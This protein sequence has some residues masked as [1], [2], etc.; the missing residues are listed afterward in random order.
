MSTTTTTTAT[1]LDSSGGRREMFA[2]LFDSEVEYCDLLATFKEQYCKPIKD[3][4]KLTKPQYFSRI[5]FQRLVVFLSNVDTICRLNF[6]FR[7]ELKARGVDGVGGVLEQ[8]APLFKMYGNYAADLHSAMECVQIQSEQ[9]DRFSKFLLQ[10]EESTQLSLSQLMRRPLERIILYPVFSSMLVRV[11]AELADLD[12][13]ESAA[14][15]FSQTSKF[16]LVQQE[17]TVKLERFKQLLNKEWIGLQ[18]LMSGN[19]QFLLEGDLTK[20]SRKVTVRYR[21]LLFNDCLVYGQSTTTSTAG[22][23]IKFK[24]SFP[25][26]GLV[27]QPDSDDDLSFLI[28][29]S[30]KSFKVSAE[31]AQVQAKWLQ[32]INLAI[33]DVKLNGKYVVKTLKPVM[34]ADTE[35]KQCMKCPKK[36]TLFYRRHHCRACGALVCEKCSLGRVRISNDLTKPKVRVCDECACKPVEELM[37]TTQQHKGGEGEGG[38]EDEEEDDYS[39]DDEV[40]VKKRESTESNEVDSTTMQCV[41]VAAHTPANA[42]LGE[43][44]VLLEGD[45]LHVEHVVNGWATGTNMRTMQSGVFPASCAQRDGELLSRTHEGRDRSSSGK[46][47][48]RRVRSGSSSGGGSGLLLQHLRIPD[49]RRSSSHL[50]SSP[51]GYP[52]PNGGGG[53]NSPQLSAGQQLRKSLGE[54]SPTAPSGTGTAAA[55]ASAERKSLA[56]PLLTFTDKRSLIMN[57]I[58]VTERTYIG[59]LRALLQVFVRPLIADFK[60]GKPQLGGTVLTQINNEDGTSMSVF[61]A[62]LEHIELLNASFLNELETR[63]QFW[64]T[65][66]EDGGGNSTACTVGDVFLRFANLFSMYDEFSSSYEFASKTL[67]DREKTDA[68]LSK[69]FEDQ[70]EEHAAVLKQTTLLSLLITP[71][72]RVPRYLLLLK[73]MQKNTPEDHPDFAL[74]GKAIDTVSKAAN[75]INEHIRERENLVH[76]REVDREFPS[77]KIASEN[78]LRM[79]IYRGTVTKQ[80]RK[81]NERYHLVLFSDMLLYQNLARKHSTVV[82][83][84]PPKRIMLDTMMVQDVSDVPEAFD[85]VSN[86]KSFRV[87]AEDVGEKTRWTKHFAEALDQLGVKA[88]KQAAPVWKQDTLNCEICAGKFT[89]TF[90]RHH[91]RACGKCICGD[92]SKNRMSVPYLEDGKPVRVCD[93]C[94]SI[95][96]DSRQLEEIVKRNMFKLGGGGGG[97]SPSSAKPS[98]TAAAAPAPRQ[99]FFMRRSSSAS[100]PPPALAR[101]GSGPISPMLAQAAAIADK[102]LKTAASA[103]GK[104]AQVEANLVA[105][106]QFGGTNAMAEIQ[107]RALERKT[108]QKEDAEEPERKRPLPPPS[109]SS[110]GVAVVA[111]AAAEVEE[112][113]PKIAFKLPS[114]PPMRNSKGDYL[115]QPPPAPRPPPSSNPSSLPARGEEEEE[116]GTPAVVVA[117]AAVAVEERPKPSQPAVVSPIQAEEEEKANDEEEKAEAKPAPTPALPARPV[118]ERPPLPPRINSHKALAGNASSSRSLMA[119]PPGTTATS[120]KAL[121]PPA[122]PRKPTVPPPRPPPS[123][124]AAVPVP[125]AAAEADETEDH[126]ASER[127]KPPIPLHR[128]A[129]FRLSIGS[130]GTS[131]LEVNGETLERELQRMRDEDIL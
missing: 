85:I 11:S 65:K 52:S 120:G 35:S 15:V 70:Q 59:A 75:H 6:E 115:P 92:C 40:G 97:E 68:K 131:S 67:V 94:F 117:A 95:K 53:R 104:R 14:E 129:S 102:E 63:L 80:S 32:A 44:L 28:L 39:S 87:V 37:K 108:R 31:S 72:Q 51:G 123:S 74:I 77:E 9:N 24:R 62:R 124:V 76:L 69:F 126:V 49:R 30:V 26:S 7:D 13:L 96:E 130:S 58:V 16:V 90:R 23:K 107:Q 128:P 1:G 78:P 41:C 103:A 79:F 88:P 46:G 42:L 56:L 34:V 118:R 82:N 17:A 25:L 50:D 113:T 48:E 89:F 110:S 66:L 122:P 100:G 36:F 71:I 47:G 45:V 99:G 127:V 22:D 101:A 106:S 91:C 98:P 5:E 19:R 60:T 18:H 2:R 84:K 125:V 83:A 111:V 116:E 61:F 21:F 29:T 43:E 33:D 114:S 8:Y 55:A 121:P 86:S 57:E 10:R 54:P 109:S 119:P 105:P 27:V 38:G 81:G 3:D 112:T 4:S 64:S 93:A 73:E 12:R 20:L